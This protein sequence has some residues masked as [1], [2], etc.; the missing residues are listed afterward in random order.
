MAAAFNKC[1]PDLLTARRFPV[2]VVSDLRARCPSGVAAAAAATSARFLSSNSAD[3]VAFAPMPPRSS[4]GT[5]Q[6]CGRRAS[7]ACSRC[8]GFRCWVRGCRWAVLLFYVD[9]VDWI[10]RCGGPVKLGVF[11][12]RRSPEEVFS[13]SV[14]GSMRGPQSSLSA[15]KLAGSRFCG[16]SSPSPTASSAA[17]ARGDERWRFCAGVS[18]VLFVIFLFMGSFLQSVETAGP[19]GAFWLGLRVVCDHVS[20]LFY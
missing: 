14:A 19:S 20:W 11:P 13:P 18:K 17:A 4:G 1:A 6:E 7:S 2:L 12:G 8:W 5:I 9:M 10:E 16:V 15:R 3:V